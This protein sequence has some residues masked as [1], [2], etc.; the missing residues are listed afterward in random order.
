MAFDVFVKI[1]GIEGESSDD[2]Y[3]GWIEVL[4]FDTGL[5]QETSST[6]SSAGGAS[7][8]RANF[9]EFSFEKA[10]D[11]ATPK[12]SLACAAGT[13]FDKIVVDL[14]RSGGD[15]IKFF[16]Y[17]LTNCILSKVK[18]LSGAAFPYETVSI[19]YGK[20][21]WRYIQ[22]KRQGGGAS[23]SIASGWN[24]QKNCKL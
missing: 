16:E 17:R 5:Y 23:G 9:K 10:C 1:D 19:N 21:K 6:A 12:L 22:Q 20:I 7:I 13:H 2:K 18:M 3:Q 4:N 8:G 14:C 24:L 11:K 15:K